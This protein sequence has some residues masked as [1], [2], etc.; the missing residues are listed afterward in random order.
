[1]FFVD[2]QFIVSDF[3][4]AFDNFFD[5]TSES[6]QFGQYSHV[7]YTEVAEVG[8]LKVK[9]HFSI[10]QKTGKYTVFGHNSASGWVFPMVSGD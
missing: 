9:A 6:V 10:F 7:F 2:F 1:M 4:L 3:S 8:F 5:C